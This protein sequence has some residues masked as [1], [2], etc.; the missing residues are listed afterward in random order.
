MS[1]TTTSSHSRPDEAG[2]HKA[3]QP[4]SPQLPAKP[5]PPAI[6]TNAAPA[7]GRLYDTI[8]QVSRASA[9]RMW[10]GISPHAIASAWFDWASHFSRA[11][12]RYAELANEAVICSTQLFASAMQP[13]A[14]EKKVINHNH[15]FDDPEWNELPFRLWRDAFL[16]TDHLCDVATR[17]LR[18]MSETNARR[19]S[20]MAHQTI[21]AF[22]P[23][24]N[25]FLNP[26]LMRRTR[27]EAGFNL[28][29]G[30][31]NLFED[32]MNALART[33]PEQDGA[34]IIGENIAATR[35]TVVYRNAIMELIQYAPATPD[36]YSEPILIVPAWIM[37]YYVLDL[38]P[39]R[40]LVKYLVD[41]GFTVFMISWKNPGESDRETPFDAYRTKGVMQALDVINAVIP[42]RQVHACGYCLGGTLLS[43]AAAAMARDQ[44]TRIASISL[45]A[46]QTDFSEAGELLL[47]VDESQIAWLEDMMWDQGFLDT[48]QM[49]GTFR[50]LR[51][52]E[53]VWS[54]LAREYLLGE[55]DSENDLTTWNADPTRM[56]YRM[57]TEYLRSLFLENRLT[58]GR[59]AVEGRVVALKDIGAPMFIVGTETDHIA[60]WRSVYKTTLFTN[61]DLTFVL[62]SGGHNAGIVSEPGHRNRHYR[63]GHRQPNAAYES[64][65]AW[66][67]GADFREG[68][69]WPVWI[70]WLASHGTG[71]RTSPPPAGAPG[72]GY[73]PLGPAPGEYVLVR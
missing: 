63:V 12:G 70:G 41:A 38:A 27:E 45:L 37:K 15:R 42:G 72:L 47:F 5:L 21:D 28:V 30:M 68:S 36:V 34:W 65:D 26:V 44:D 60:P 18:G 67:G 54:R 35:G 11:P 49:A 9:S 8:S 31:N 43:I 69:W 19:V 53:L 13:N 14:V 22:S 51:A 23:A 10:G 62:T 55:R 56:P 50:L 40:S 48:H 66:A 71:E 2:P 33:P 3:I 58:A 52:N 7:P 1:D 4:A 46:A 61:N 25:L 59:Y 16:A 29:R 57:H 24:N 73:E 64:P 6:D 32:A 39:C 17:P 20:F